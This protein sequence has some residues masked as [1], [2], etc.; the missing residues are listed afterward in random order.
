MN[1]TQYRGWG[2]SGLPEDIVWASTEVYFDDLN[3]VI[4]AGTYYFVWLATTSAN[5]T[6]LSVGSPILAIASGEFPT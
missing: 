6:T 3:F 2:G 4:P 5:V 1:A